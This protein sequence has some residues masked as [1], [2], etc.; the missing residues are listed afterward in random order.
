MYGKKIKYVDFNDTERE[1]TFYFHLS[2]A[3][4]IKIEAQYEGGFEAYA[5]RMVEA[6]KTEDLVNVLDDLIARSYGVK[7][8]DGRQFVKNETVLNDFKQTQAYSDLF[9]QLLSDDK[10]AE[11]FIIGIMPRDVDKDEIKR[12]V[13]KKKSE[14]LGESN[15]VA[16]PAV[17][18]DSNA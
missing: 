14:I 13:E 9:I 10:A 5:N 17:Q 2:Q 3:D 15:V 6:R 12:Q 11:E 16:M 1:E 8:L 4:L 7:S 18:G